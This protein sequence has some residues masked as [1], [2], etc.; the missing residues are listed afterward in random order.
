MD[1]ISVKSEDVQTRLKFKH[2][3]CGVNTATATLW[4]VL[5]FLDEF[6]ILLTIKRPKVICESESYKCD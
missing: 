3:I 4:I 2:L 5:G 1:Y 6:S